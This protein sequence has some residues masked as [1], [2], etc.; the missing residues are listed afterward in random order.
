[1]DIHISNTNFD[2]TFPV[3]D[4][5]NSI[6]HLH[7][8]IMNFHHAIMQLYFYKWVRRSSYLDLWRSKIWYMK[9]N[10]PIIEFRQSVI[11]I[12]GYVLLWSS[13]TEL[14]RSI[15]DHSIETPSMVEPQWNI[16]Y[17]GSRWIF[18][19]VFPAEIQLAVS[20]GQPLFTTL[21]LLMF[22]LSL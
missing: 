15:S 13:I 3:M 9:L 4:L 10:K 22:A 7:D 14:R 17:W 20:G 11:E 5:H 1:M 18:H 8:L 16:L 21:R 19:T 2:N 6:M 12:H